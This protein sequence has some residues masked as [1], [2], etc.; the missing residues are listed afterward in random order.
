MNNVGR[1][2]LSGVDG[3]VNTVEDYALDQVV[4]SAAEVEYLDRYSITESQSLKR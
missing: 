1:G 4:G 2:R 3:N